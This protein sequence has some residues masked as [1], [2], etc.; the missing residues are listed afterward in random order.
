[1]KSKLLHVPS[2]NKQSQRPYHRRSR[3]DDLFQKTKQKFDLEESRKRAEN[4]GYLKFTLPESGL[5][6]KKSGK[7]KERPIGCLTTAETVICN[8]KPTN[9]QVRINVHC[10][11]LQKSWRNKILIELDSS[12]FR[13]IIFF[14]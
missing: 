7:K 5:L 9:I 14:D 6:D 12:G 1:M 10:N 11:L 4:D 3:S 2:D 8:N 13:K